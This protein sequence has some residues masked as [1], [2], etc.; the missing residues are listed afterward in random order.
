MGIKRLEEK[1]TSFRKYL[2]IMR[3][4]EQIFWPSLQILLEEF[5]GHTLIRVDIAW[6]DRERGENARNCHGVRHMRELDKRLWI[7][8]KLRSNDEIFREQ[9][10]HLWRM[11][12][13]SQFNYQLEFCE[14]W[15]KAEI[16]V[17]KQVRLKQRERGELATPHIFSIHLV[18]CESIG[19]S[20]EQLRFR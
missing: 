19:K 14:R 9:W 1:P 4:S 17:Q 16:L 2:K 20:R 3:M 5:A 15:A 6:S 18:D 8:Q 11:I 13:S 10:A 12:G 7:Q